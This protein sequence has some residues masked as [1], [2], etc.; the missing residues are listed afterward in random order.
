MLLRNLTILI[1]IIGLSLTYLPNFWWHVV[2][3]A[4]YFLPWKSFTSPMIH[5]YHSFLISRLPD[6]PERPALELPLAEASLETLSAMSKGFTVPVIIRGALKDAP[7]LTQVSNQL[8]NH[9]HLDQ[10]L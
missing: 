10:F 9:R 2:I 5:A 7:A 3:L 4:D 8:I 1:A 6:Q